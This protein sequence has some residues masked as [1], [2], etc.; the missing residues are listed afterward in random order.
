MGRNINQLN[1]NSMILHTL[2]IGEMVA[3]DH[4]GKWGYI[5]L[6]NGK[7]EDL[8]INQETREVVVTLWDRPFIEEKTSEWETFAEDCYQV[9]EGKFYNGEIVCIEHL[10]YDVC[11]GTMYYCPAEGLNIFEVELD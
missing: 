11:Y 10:K 8:L 2:H 5:K 9:A 3:D 7:E 1:L 6:I 4:N